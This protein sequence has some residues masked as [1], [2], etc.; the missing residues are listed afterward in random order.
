MGIHT[1]RVDILV[2]IAPHLF[3]SV[4]EIRC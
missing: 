1:D 4:M 3:S 2:L